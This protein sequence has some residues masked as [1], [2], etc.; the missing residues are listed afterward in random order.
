MKKAFL[1][2]IGLLGVAAV[3]CKKA[4]DAPPGYFMSANIGASSFDVGTCAVSIG[5][6]SFAMLAT[7]GT[8]HGSNLYPEIGINVY[9]G[10]TGPGRYALDSNSYY[11]KADSN[12]VSFMGVAYGT[13]TITGSDPFT[14]TFSFTCKD[15]TKVT[16]GSFIAKTN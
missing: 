14:G 16:N 1:L 8:S 15:S 13:V 4:N 7:S 3:G 9:S 10:Y 12:S 6:S 11:A 5:N 2:V